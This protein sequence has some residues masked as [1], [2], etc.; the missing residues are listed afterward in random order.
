MAEL[1]ALGTVK[2]IKMFQQWIIRSQVLTGSESF[3]PRMQFTD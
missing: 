1:I 2:T 3:Q